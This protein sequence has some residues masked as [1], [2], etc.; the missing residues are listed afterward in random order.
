VR[1]VL[2]EQLVAKRRPRGIA[3]EG[4][5]IGLRFQRQ[6]H[7]V[8]HAEQC[9]GRFAGAIGEWRQRVERAVQIAGTVNEGKSRTRHRRSIAG[10]VA[11]LGPGAIDLQLA[12][13]RAFKT[14]S[15]RRASSAGTRDKRVNR[16]FRQSYSRK[17]AFAML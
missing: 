17:D 10:G 11:E 2:G 4:D 5:V 8:E 9:A 15:R 1:L 14:S 13:G 6:A 16:T 3:D 12:A 7:H